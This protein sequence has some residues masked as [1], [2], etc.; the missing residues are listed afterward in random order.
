[1]VSTPFK[2]IVDGHKEE[3]VLQAE[4]V[5]FPVLLTGKDYIGTYL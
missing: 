2:A 4:A 5:D 3:L 1:M